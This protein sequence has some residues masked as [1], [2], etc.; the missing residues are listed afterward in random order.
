[1]NLDL[2]IDVCLYAGLDAY[3][4]QWLQLLFPAYV[5]ILVAIVIFIS[6][7][8]SRFARL[9]RR[10]N[11]VATLATL[12]LL[13]YAKFLRAIIDIF[14]FAILKFPDG[15][16]RM[17]WLPDATVPYLG[18]KHIPLFLTAVII[19]VLGILYTLILV[20]WQWLQQLPRKWFT[21][22]IWNTRLNSFMDA[23]LA[24]Y[25]PKHR[26]W[27][28]L[29]LFSRVT[30]YLVSVLNL[31]NNPRI[32]LLAVNL[33]ISCFF[34]LKVVFLVRVHIKLPIELLDYSFY[35][36]I[37]LLS[38]ASFY[39]LGDQQ[40][41]IIAT[42]T[43]ISIAMVLF[44]GIVSY[45]I[46]CVVNITGCVQT[47]KNMMVVNRKEDGDTHANLL[48]NEDGASQNALCYPI[49]STI[50]EISP[51]HHHSTEYCIADELGKEASATE[52]QTHSDSSQ[53]SSMHPSNST[54]DS[55]DI[56][57]VGCSKSPSSQEHQCQL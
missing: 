6:E 33:V 2:G 3:S 21:Q 32:T 7:R 15:S 27:T 23:Y 51:T 28:G 43:S 25:T 41:Q 57:Q 36:N 49:T 9:V 50:V 38:L 16:S 24:P 40:G 13:S 19:L 1:M 52:M 22:W 42:Y 8:S 45:H 31:S 48:I 14:S 12:I 26:Y 44:F 35:L 34:V 39:S 56:V 11:P 20:L 54:V 29:L 55:E 5:I 30:L 4:K 10:G 53:V 18:S 47:L 37:L 17:V 46:L